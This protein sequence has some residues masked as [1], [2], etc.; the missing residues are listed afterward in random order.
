MGGKKSG[1]QVREEAVETEMVELQRV[2]DSEIILMTRIPIADHLRTISEMKILT[3]PGSDRK[4]R[5][6]L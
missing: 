5:Q 3:R 2:E 1:H 6:L 4:S